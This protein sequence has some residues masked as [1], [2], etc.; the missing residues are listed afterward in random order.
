MG[1]F[2]SKLF[3]SGKGWLELFL[4]AMVWSKT[5]GQVYGRDRSESKFLGSEMT[6]AKIP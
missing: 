6:A 1:Q 3:K 4:D 5:F 2:G